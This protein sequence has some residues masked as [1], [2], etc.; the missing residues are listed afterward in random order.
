MPIYVAAYLQPK[1]AGVPYAMEDI[2]LRG[3]YQVVANTSARDSINEGAKKAGMLVYTQ[4]DGKI[5]VLNPDLATWSNLSQSINSA[6]TTVAGLMSAGDK[7]ILDNLN[8]NALTGLSVNTPLVTSGG[9]APTLSM[10]AATSS[11]S[12]YLTSSDWVLFNSKGSGNGTVMGITATAPLIASTSSTSPNISLPAASSTTSGYLTSTDWVI[13]NSKASGTGSIS[14]ITGT[15]PIVVSSGQTPVVSMQAATSSVDGYLKAIDWITF[16]SKGNGTVQSISASIGSPITVQSGVNTII[17]MPVATSSQ[18]GYLASA[19]WVAFNN[20]GNGIVQSITASAGQPI[21]VTGTT[22][23]PVIGMPAATPTAPGYMSAEDKQKLNSI[24]ANAATYVHPTGDGNLHVPATGSSNNGKFLMA[25]ASAGML[26]W[27]TPIG[28]VT[29][30]NGQTGAVTLS[31]T[32]IGLST[33]SNVQYNNGRFNSLGVG[34]AASGT[35]GEIRA[36]NNITAYY[37]S[38]RRLKEN[39]SNITEA[40]SKV[41]RLNGVEFDWTQDYLDKHGGEDEYFNRKHDVGL[42]AQEVVAVLP[43]VVAT[44]EDGTLAVKYDRV[45]ALLVEAVK[46]LSAEVR[47]LKKI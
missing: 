43:E 39:I 30:V 36:T 14:S 9:R 5:W 45:V 18:N 12:G 7:V 23:N 28:G 44:R 2:Y 8:N 24:E 46:E 17:G 26:S 16:N 32:D 21:T 20:K 15:A 25:G 37:S 1:S 31:A 42:I 3:G 13:F 35:A 41:N 6:S 38:D 27:G 33:T 19:D 10:P 22:V 29:S 34:T 11:Q 40:L 47:E 4:S